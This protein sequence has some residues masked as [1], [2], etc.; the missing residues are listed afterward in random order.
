MCGP[1]IA[2]AVWKSSTLRKWLL[3]FLKL[4]MEI[5]HIITY[6]MIYLFLLYL[7]DWQKYYRLKIVS[8]FLRH[9]VSRLMNWMWE[10]IKWM[11]TIF[12]THYASLQWN[13][14]SVDRPRPMGLL[15]YLKCGGGLWGGGGG[16]NVFLAFYAISNISRKN[17][18]GIKKNI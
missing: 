16:G 12:K 11:T 17:N 1:H 8:F 4:D 13:R 14:N 2:S 5:D 18:S 9:P 3:R 6:T 7:Q 10:M 15:F